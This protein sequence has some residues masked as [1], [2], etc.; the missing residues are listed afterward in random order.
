[1]PPGCVDSRMCCSAAVLL[2][3]LSDVA[4]AA[5]G[6]PQ[7]G[8]VFGDMRSLI[9]RCTC[10]SFSYFFIA[11]VCKEGNICYA[12]VGSGGCAV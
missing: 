12:S 2:G 10:L 9:F 6:R 5:R 8:D 7:A 11:H 3:G 4:I 1:M